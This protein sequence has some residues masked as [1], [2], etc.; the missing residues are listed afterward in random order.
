MKTKEQ[1]FLNIGV[2][3]FLLLAFSFRLPFLVFLPIDLIPIIIFLVV[4]NFI[5]IP[6]KVSCALIGLIEG[7]V[8]QSISLFLMIFFGYIMGSIILYELTPFLTLLVMPSL[9]F[10]FLIIKGDESDKIGKAIWYWSMY[11][12]A[13]V[14]IYIKFYSHLGCIGC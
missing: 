8:V 10:Y 2:L 13:A 3:V 7:L 1:L 9:V 12:L 4:I 5:K 6:A 14:F 11:L